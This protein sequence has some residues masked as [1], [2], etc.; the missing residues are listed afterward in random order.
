VTGRDPTDV[1]GDGGH[2]RWATAWHDCSAARGIGATC[3][4]SGLSDGA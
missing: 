1:G 4:I 3:A 2:D